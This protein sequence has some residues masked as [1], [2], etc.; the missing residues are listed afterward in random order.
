[1]ALAREPEEDCVAHVRPHVR[2]GAVRQLVVRQDRVASA[3]GQLARRRHRN[4]REALQQLIG[5]VGC[6]VGRQRAVRPGPYGEVPLERLGDVAEEHAAQRREVVDGA[7]RDA[8]ERPRHA[9]DVGIGILRLRDLLRKPQRDL[10]RRGWRQHPGPDRRLGDFLQ[11]GA[12]IKVQDG[13]SGDQL[14][15][16]RLRAQRPDL[17]LVDPLFAQ[18]VVDRLQRRVDPRAR[19]RVADNQIA[20]VE[21]RPLSFRLESHL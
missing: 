18:G 5:A 20:V 17:A 6:K 1:M 8:V 14:G 3:G 4:P 9:V 15:T 12:P 10:P 13:V 7:R 2:R 21:E 11:G 19:H 16:E